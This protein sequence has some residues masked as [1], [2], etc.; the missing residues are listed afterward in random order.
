MLKYEMV[1]EVA[2]TSSSSVQEM[3]IDVVETETTDRNN[4]SERGKNLAFC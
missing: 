4:A 2:V 1:Y 3:V